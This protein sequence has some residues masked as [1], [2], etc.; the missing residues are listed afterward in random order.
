MPSTAISAGIGAAISAGTP[1]RKTGKTAG[2]E[3]LL[4][5]TAPGQ[6]RWPPAPPCAP[7]R[8]RRRMAAAFPD[9][10]ALDV[11]EP[12]P[13]FHPQSPP[14]G[15]PWV[16]WGL[17]LA[18]AL[19]ELVL[20]GA[21]RGLWGNASWRPLSVQYGGFWAGLL[22][23]WKPNFPGQK[24]TMFATYG[25]LHAGGTHLAGNLLG[26]LFLGPG[27]VARLG[28]GRF[29]GLY[30]GAV[31]GGAAAFG[32][33]ATSAAPMVGA[34]GAVFGLAGAATFWDWQRLRRPWRTAGIVAGLAAFNLV[35]LVTTGGQLAWQTHLGG[36]LA[37]GL[38]AL[39]VGR[40]A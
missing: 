35:T 40:R 13:S 36:F 22:Q 4:R 8:L 18:V 7:A 26:I 29:L 9:P 24:V 11:T 27:G 39:W 32:L 3:P 12:R 28:P 34:S 21:E 1:R 30:A 2:A 5:R 17:A 16:L 38:V 23:G 20:M 10:V 33:L 37:G 31:L 14:L 19:P 6:I 25:F 15:L